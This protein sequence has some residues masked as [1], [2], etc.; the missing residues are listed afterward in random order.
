MPA[1]H[2]FAREEELPS[3]SAVFYQRKIHITNQKSHSAADIA[4]ERKTGDSCGIAPVFI[5]CYSKP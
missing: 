2:A 5:V 4:G 3:F 1:T